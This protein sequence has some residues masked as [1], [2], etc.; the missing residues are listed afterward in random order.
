MVDWL[1]TTFLH[2]PEQSY[3]RAL[4]GRAALE[5]RKMSEMEKNVSRHYGF[6]DIMR[7]IRR[8]L[9]R[10]G[11]DVEQLTIDDLAPVDAFHTRG[12]ASTVELANLHRP[13]PA[14]EVLD[15]GCGLGGSARFL[16]DRF[17]CHVTGIDLTDQYIRAARQLTEWT[18]MDDRVR[19]VQGSAVELPFEDG[20]WNI[21]WTEHAQ[22]NIS[23]KDRFY[24]EIARV[25]KPGGALMFHDIF[26]GA[27][28]PRF[29][30]PWA[31]EAS[32]SA[33]ATCKQAR[34]SMQR[35][36]LVIEQWSDRVAESLQFFETALANI[37]ENGKPPLGIHLLMGD[38]AEEKI[39]NYI[40]GL[41]RQAIFVAL[42]VARKEP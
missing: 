26:G 1:A 30:V 33:L 4:I 10:A 13:K 40:D 23:D 20:S 21:V 35:A 22:M 24:S 3:T 32:L 17:G 12:R 9:D 29:P 11:K 38:T 34:E 2:I 15:V 6:S 8:G 7:A 14:H 31:E 19:F 36:G 28:D 41:R 42:G 25:L 18:G 37:Q 5:R 27:D 39:A 16:A